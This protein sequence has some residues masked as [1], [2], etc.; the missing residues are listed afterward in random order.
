MSGLVWPKVLQNTV[1]CQAYED[2]PIRIAATYS[3]SR[4][5]SP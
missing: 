3:L 1:N 4:D 2:L 5:G